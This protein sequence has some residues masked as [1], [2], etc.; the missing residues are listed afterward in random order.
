MS[1][2]LHEI[3]TKGWL[4]T[5][6]AWGGDWWR[7]IHGATLKYP[8]KPTPEEKRM[9]VTF[10]SLIP[11]YI[12]CADCSVHFLDEMKMHPLTDE[13]L[14]S[15]PRVVQWGIDLHNS[16][17]RRLGK[18]EV[19]WDQMHAFFYLDMRH[20][21]RSANTTGKSWDQLITETKVMHARDAMH[22]NPKLVMPAIFTALGCAATLLITSLTPKRHNNNKNA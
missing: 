13:I 14:S 6:S 15:G 19:T 1:E 20:E 12:P 7:V 4:Y 8:L 10:V 17:N 5:Y 22:V 3:E 9:F 11:L 21:P 16:V 2:P 18:P